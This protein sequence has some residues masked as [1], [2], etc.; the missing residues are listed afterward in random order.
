MQ[1]PVIIKSVPGNSKITS[2]GKQISVFFAQVWEIFS[3][4]QLRLK[5]VI[6]NFVPKVG[7][8]HVF[9]HPVTLVSKWYVLVHV[10][11]VLRFYSNTQIQTWIAYESK[12]CIV[13]AL[14]I[15]SASVSQ[16]KMLTT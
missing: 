12:L 5:N 16:G 7:G 8:V 11:K 9:K 3:I 10:L 14:D 15:E 1:V 4:E 13:L 6:C 2:A